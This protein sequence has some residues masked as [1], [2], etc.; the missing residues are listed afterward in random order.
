[1]RTCDLHALEHLVGANE[2]P[3][4]MT[5]DGSRLLGCSDLLD[6]LYDGALIGS[7]SCANG[8]VAE[9]VHAIGTHKKEGNVVI[10]IDGV[11]VLVDTHGVVTFVAL[12]LQHLAAPQV[13]DEL[14][15]VAFLWK[16]LLQVLHLDLVKVALNDDADRPFLPHSRWWGAI[17]RANYLFWGL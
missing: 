9:S 17:Q 4:G 1:M 2:C 6:E 10:K 15:P 8:L 7:V 14:H 13:G 11:D 5:N 3:E 12:K 16:F